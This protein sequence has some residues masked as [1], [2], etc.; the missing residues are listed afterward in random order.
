MAL[1]VVI[2]ILQKLAGDVCIEFLSTDV[3]KTGSRRLKDIYLI[4]LR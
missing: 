3:L 1:L 4:F 2:F